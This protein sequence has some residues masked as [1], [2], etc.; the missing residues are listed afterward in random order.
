MVRMR[1]REV[2]CELWK[3]I[4]EAQVKDVGQKGEGKRQMLSRVERRT[5]YLSAVSNYDGGN[6]SVLSCYSSILHLINVYLPAANNS[7]IFLSGWLA[8]LG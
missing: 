6:S 7:P 3:N 8:M 1:N 5:P 4:A 2:L